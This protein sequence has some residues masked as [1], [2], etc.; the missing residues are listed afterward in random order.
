ME[1]PRLAVA[2]AAAQTATAVPASISRASP[3]TPPAPQPI[4]LAGLEHLVDRGERRVR[5]GEVRAGDEQHTRSQGASPSPRGAA[6]A[7]S[8]APARA[9]GPV[10]R[11][12][13]MR[14]GITG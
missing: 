12:V 2:K 4:R 7:A 5:R 3:I 6:D 13:P 8:S 11:P 10:E 9:S 1:R 14:T